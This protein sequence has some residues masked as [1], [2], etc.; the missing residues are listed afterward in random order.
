MPRAKKSSGSFRC[1]KCDRVFSMKAHLA[2][3]MGTIHMS[4]S[5][6]ANAKTKRKKGR[7]QPVRAVGR[8]KGV[9]ARVGLRGMSLEQLRDV[10]DA[11]RAEAQVKIA[12]YQ[13]SFG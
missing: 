13:R 2:R 6:K 12:E 4:P 3:H 5:A 10:I 11:A 7:R 8:P 1:S 9:T